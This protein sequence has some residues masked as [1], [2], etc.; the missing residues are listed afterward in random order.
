MVGVMVSF[1]PIAP[2]GELEAGPESIGK[3]NENGEFVLTATSGGKSGA[4]VGRH[5]VQISAYGVAT[6][7]EGADEDDTRRGHRRRMV[8]TIPARWNVE[9]KET[10]EVKPE[11]TDQANFE[12]GSP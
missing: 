4:C 11:G 8:E 3:T 9:S 6:S 12:L 2:E 1:Q 5:R 10:F 7:K